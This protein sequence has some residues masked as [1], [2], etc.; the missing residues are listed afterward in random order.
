MS[1]FT[2]KISENDYEIIIIKKN[3]DANPYIRNEKAKKIKK[4]IDLKGTTNKK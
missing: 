2:V 3:H 1:T 4:F